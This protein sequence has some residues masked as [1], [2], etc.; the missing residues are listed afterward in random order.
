LGCHGSL[1]LIAMT[2]ITNTQEVPLEALM[3]V[4][5]KMANDTT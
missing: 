4:R 1:T 5:G 2:V 3:A